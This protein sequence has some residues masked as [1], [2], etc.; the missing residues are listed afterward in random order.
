MNKEPN[1]NQSM[2]EDQQLDHADML[3]LI[4]KFKNIIRTSNTS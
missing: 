4:A 1:S 3:E 2:L